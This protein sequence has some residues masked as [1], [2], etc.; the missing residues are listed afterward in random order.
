MKNI[1]WKSI[2]VTSVFCLLPVLFGLASW[3]NLPERVAIHFDFNSNPDRFASKEFAVFAMPVIMA[4][5]Q[6]FLCVVTDINALKHGEK[7]FDRAMKWII[8]V[9]TVVLQIVILGYALGWAVD[10]RRAVALVV[11]VMFIMI[12]SFL[13]ELD[14]IKN[15][16]LPKEKA[17]K[18]NRFVGCITVVLGALFAISVFL[19]SVATMACILLIIPYTVVTIV[20]FFK[21]K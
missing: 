15:Y 6:A 12:G 10:I 20:Y 11:A 4:L 19:P 7:K 2:T 13:P 16:K 8:P 5:L 3:E 21:N 14:Y 9:M 18:I 1:K 17:L